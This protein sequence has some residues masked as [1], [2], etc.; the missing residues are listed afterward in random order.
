[1]LRLSLFSRKRWYKSQQKYQ[2]S[3]H[4]SFLPFIV[5]LSLCFFFFFFFFFFWNKKK[6]G[7]RKN[8]R[9]LIS[10][11]SCGPIFLA[12]VFFFAVPS[13][14]PPFFFGF[15]SLEF[16]QGEKKYLFVLFYNF[17]LHIQKLIN[18]QRQTSVMRIFCFSFFFFPLCFVLLFQIIPQL[19]HHHLSTFILILLNCLSFFHS[20]VFLLLKR[21]STDGWRKKKWKN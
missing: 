7:R 8:A 11:F 16:F 15:F 5:A 18:H 17:D 21:S 12:F 10:L 1:M 9:G 3:Y 2:S 19:L 13:L 6:R 14:H 4:H 20:L